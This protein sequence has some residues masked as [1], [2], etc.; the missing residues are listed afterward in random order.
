MHISIQIQGS[1]TV[2]EAMKGKLSCS[3]VIVLHYANDI[4]AF[5]PTAMKAKYPN[6]R[7][8]CTTLG[9][10]VHVHGCQL[11]I[12]TFL[13]QT[14]IRF[15]QITSRHTTWHMSCQFY[16]HVHVKNAL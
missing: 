16:S 3:I 9:D 4:H 15:I 13:E 14:L 5:M 6:A 12:P 8:V 7:F 10:K 2:K 11:S 1:N